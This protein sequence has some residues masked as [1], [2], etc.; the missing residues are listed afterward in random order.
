[1]C[2][3]QA[4]REGYVAMIG[5]NIALAQRLAELIGDTADL[6]LRYQGLSIVTFRFNPGPAALAGLAVEDQSESDSNGLLNRIN[7]DILKKLQ[8]EGWAYPSHAHIDNAFLLR[9]CI[10]NFR[11][12]ARDIDLLPA[13]VVDLGQS[14]I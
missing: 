11:S 5:D 8:A 9:V 13:K 2:L 12:S 3:R 7:R 1:M 6:E 14:L 10:T 4:G